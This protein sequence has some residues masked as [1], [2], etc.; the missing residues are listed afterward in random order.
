MRNKGKDMDKKQSKK[1]IKDEYKDM[2][3]DL[4]EGWR[5]TTSDVNDDHDEEGNEIRLYSITL[6]KN[7]KK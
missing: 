4:D 7:K 3:S 1:Q 6:I 5:Y 2:V